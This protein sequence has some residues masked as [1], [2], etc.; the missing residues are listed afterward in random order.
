MV[1]NITSGYAIYVYV[2]R[3]ITAPP[4]PPPQH[5]YFKAG[6]PKTHGLKGFLMEG[7]E[8]WGPKEAGVAKTRV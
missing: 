8:I 1:R 2:A 5:T 6:D 7:S 4:P 3:G